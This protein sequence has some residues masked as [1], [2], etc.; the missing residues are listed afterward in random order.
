MTQTMTPLSKL[1][2]DGKWTDGASDEPLEVINPA[3]EQV[4]S[5]VPSGGVREVVAAVAAARRA[6]D[7]G[8]WP[9]TTPAERAAV[10]RLMGEVMVRRQD[11]LVALNVAEAGST[12]L[13]ASFLQVGAPI[14]HFFDTADRVLPRFDFET[15][16]PPFAKPGLGVGSGIICREP[17]GV[18]ALITPFNF[19]LLLN[20]LKVTAALAAGCTAVLT[21]SPDTPLEALI[22]GEIAEEAG[23]PAGVL[24]VVTGGV[25][26][27]RELTQNPMID[28]VSF[29]GSDVVGRKVYT[30]AAEGLKRVVL[31]LGGKSANV[32]F[33][34]ANLEGA[35]ASMV[36]NLSVHSGQGCSL[37]T[38]S[39]VHRSVHDELV[40]RAVALM[41]AI[42]VGDPADDTITMGP[43]IRA[44]QR[45]RV[46]RFVETARQDGAQVV[47]GGG[48][49]A[50]LD[51]GFFFE[52]TL[53]TDVRND[54]E[55]A[56]RELFGPVGVVIPFNTEEEA[57]RL[58]NESDYG[59]GGGVWSGDPLRALTVAKQI[60]TGWV[61][62]NG[63]GPGPNPHGPFGGYKHS[64]LGREQGEFGLAEYLVSKA[65]TWPISAG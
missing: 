34:D 27:A 39:L 17:V 36:Q 45:D 32:I 29:T 57:V 6:F 30:Q 15:P 58:A 50:G 18:A 35:A 33:P 59:L 5:Q 53:L 44:S 7:E 11:E 63:G 20:V 37:L 23:V 14:G 60:R 9:R 26:A 48:R 55:I 42:K 19:P 31:E 10:L 24:N 56:Q 52:P 61:D 12:Q 16:M 22:L 51:R 1:Y 40:E 54:S 13:L 49:P 21:P 65:I 28:I 38:R 62:I 4:Y 8:P 25:D 2:I 43:L 3:T 64:G 47:A 46:E 41:G